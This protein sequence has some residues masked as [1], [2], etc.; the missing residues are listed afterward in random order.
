MLVASECSAP[1]DIVCT[2]DK[3]CGCLTL[4]VVNTSEKP[5]TAAIRIKGGGEYRATKM[6]TI[7]GKLDD[8]NTMENPARI[9]PVE[10]SASDMPTFPAYSFSVLQ[11]S[12]SKKCEQYSMHPEPGLE[13][14]FRLT[15]VVR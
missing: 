10:V 2:A 8:E 15:P 1:L 3:D 7:S 12:K 11:M 6:K 13:F 4:L 5:V 9:V 14:V